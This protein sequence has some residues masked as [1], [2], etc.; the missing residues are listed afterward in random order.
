MVFGG[1]VYQVE[2]EV[3]VNNA[4]IGVKDGA[5]LYSTYSGVSG[6]FWVLGAPTIANWASAQICV[7][8]SNGEMPMDARRIRATEMRQHKRRERDLERQQ[9]T[10]ENGEKLATELAAG[11]ATQTVARKPEAAS[12]VY[13][14]QPDYSHLINDLYEY[15]KEMNDA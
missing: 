2:T 12:P 11:E 8:T 13:I 6:N 4:Q 3:P 10:A 14:P 9:A 5:T 1:T 15:E 7:R